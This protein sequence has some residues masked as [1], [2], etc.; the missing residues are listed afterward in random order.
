MRRLLT[1]GVGTVAA[2]VLRRDLAGRPALAALPR[3]F[4]HPLLPFLTAL[5]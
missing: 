4:R 3:E 1:L 2:L 5:I